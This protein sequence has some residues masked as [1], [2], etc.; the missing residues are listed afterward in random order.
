MDG[1]L[2][3]KIFLV[4]QKRQLDP[5]EI[6]CNFTWERTRAWF[7]LPRARCPQQPHCHMF[8][9]TACDSIVLKQGLTPQGK[10]SGQI[11]FSTVA[12]GSRLRELLELGYGSDDLYGIVI[13]LLMQGKVRID[14]P[15]RSERL[16]LQDSGGKM[17]RSTA[18]QH[19]EEFWE[20]C[21]GIV[22]AHAS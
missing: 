14:H 12:L 4:W 16:E 2:G 19:F 15:D 13:P 6:Y 9:S 11:S 7:S 3:R 17:A 20:A 18:I 22:P 8:R 21:G 10:M 5:A 1:R